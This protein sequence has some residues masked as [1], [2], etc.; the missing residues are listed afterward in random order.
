MWVCEHHAAEG[1]GSWD[2]AQPTSLV[3]G[4]A[5]HVIVHQQCDR[6]TAVPHGLLLLSSPT[7][8]RLLQDSGVAAHHQCGRG[9]SHNQRGTDCV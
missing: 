2:A 3:V 1:V 5:L 7:R 4:P 9:S 8:C 6:V